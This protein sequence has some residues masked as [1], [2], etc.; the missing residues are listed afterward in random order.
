MTGLNTGTA[1][2][3]E[4]SVAY[5]NVADDQAGQ[6]VD[7]FLMARFRGL[8]RSRVYR[9][10]RRGEV[11]VNGGRIG[12]EHRLQAGDRVRLPPVDLPPP[13][14][15]GEAPDHQLR[16][17]T[18]RILFENERLLVLD[19]P[20]G[21]ACHGG[22]GVSFGVIEAL[23]Q[24][25][26]NQPFFELVHR[27]DRDTSGCLLIAKRRSTLR[28][29]HEQL[30]SGAVGKRYLALLVGQFPGRRQRVDAALDRYERGGERLVRVATD[31]KPAQTVFH[32]RERF[33]GAS[34]VEAELLSGRTHQIRVHAQHLGCPVAGDPKYG[35]PAAEAALGAI[36]LKRLFLHAAKIELAPL[37]DDT[38]Q[39]FE[40]PLPAALEA[41]LERLRDTQTTQRTA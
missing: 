26:P 38:P 30:R 6:R 31:G 23:R 34:L 35:D 9:L 18:G 27:L 21:L 17:L 41:V 39:V 29:L 10:L 7:N 5:V 16:E 25:R 33:A 11:R 4:R 32:L 36:G 15:P 20:A 8:P 1:T 19:K 14:P 28:A 37:D 13:R 22:S 2:T 12:P 24:L 40:A 3:P